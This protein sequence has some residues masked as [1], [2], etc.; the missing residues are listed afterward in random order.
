M[1][2]LQRSTKVNHYGSGREILEQKHSYT[3]ELYSAV[4]ENFGNIAALEMIE[5][6][7]QERRNNQ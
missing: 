7:L 2:E 5:D 3:L 1:P 6:I 4:A